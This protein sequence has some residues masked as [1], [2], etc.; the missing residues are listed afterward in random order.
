MSYFFTYGAIKNISLKLDRENNKLPVEFK[1]KIND[2]RGMLNIKSPKPKYTTKYIEKLDYETCE[3]YKILNK[4]SDKNYDKLSIEMKEIIDRVDDDIIQ[5][6]LCE[7]I[8]NIAS[9]NS[10][11]S[12]L[13]A[14]L[15]SD[16]NRTYSSFSAMFENAFDSYCFKFKNIVYVSANED[17]DLY[18]EYIK[19]IDAL[20]AFM[21]FM[22]NLVN[23]EMFSLK[24]MMNFIIDL[25][26]LLI[27]NIKDDT[28]VIENE[29]YI[30]NIFIAVRDMGKRLKTQSEWKMFRNNI[31]L[32]HEAKGPGKSNK[33]RF[34]IMDINDL[35]I[36]LK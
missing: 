8:M 18:C 9:K 27:E 14:K 3:I 26:D 7:K 12:K 10:F 2:L 4:L 11:Y 30:N 17:Y 22:I 34:K 32:I 16:L 19:Q 24:R 15:I 35:L 36:K 29:G 23:T 20:E 33:T 31:K 28:K 1:T 5:N 6:R 13:Y 21:M 25:Q